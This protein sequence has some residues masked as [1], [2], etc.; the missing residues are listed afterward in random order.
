MT[1]TASP[2]P[3]TEL[4]SGLEVLQRAGFQVEVSKNIFQKWD[5]FAGTDE[6]RARSFFEMAMS[7]HIDVIYCARGGYGSYRL[8]P[9]LDEMVKEKGNPPAEKLLVGSS[10][11]TLLLEYAMN[12]WGWQGLLAPMPGNRAFSLMKKKE[13]LPLFEWIRGH[14]TTEFDWEG[15]RLKKIGKVSRDVKGV[16]RGGNLATWLGCVGTP[17]QVTLKESILFLEDIAET[18]SRMDRMFQQITQSGALEG[19]RAIILG[20]FLNCRDSV[21]TAVK[22]STRLKDWNQPK[23]KH[24]QPLRKQL[25]DLKGMKRVFAEVGD[26]LNI[27]V[28]AGLLV[29]H[30]PHYHALP[31]GVP[32][33]LTEEGKFSLIRAGSSEF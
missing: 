16:I 28:Y 21:P 20:D 9:L 33:N 2:V 6:V 30:G 23:A 22:K 26:Q 8:L 12:R 29:G 15:R 5:F 24:L 13:R 1:A 19:V 3:R 32:A 7:P 4:E 18:W 27:P 10:D 14:V 25:S 31:L 17:Y 11:V